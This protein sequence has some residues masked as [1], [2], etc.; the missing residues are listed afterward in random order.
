MGP[1]IRHSLITAIGL[2]A[3]DGTS[4]LTGLLNR[5]V[6]EGVGTYFHLKGSLDAEQYY[7]LVYSAGV[8]EI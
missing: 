4:I 8:L 5:E 3:G 7:T 1:K 2:Q 6:G